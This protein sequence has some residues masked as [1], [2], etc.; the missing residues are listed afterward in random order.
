MDQHSSRTGFVRPA[1]PT[2]LTIIPPARQPSPAIS[3]I[4][5]PHHFHSGPGSSGART[6]T[7]T[8]PQNAAQKRRT[9]LLSLIDELAQL[10]DEDMERERFLQALNDEKNTGYNDDRVQ[11]EGV[12]AF[13]KFNNR[14]H[15]LDKELQSFI[16]AVRQLGSSVGLL[17]SAYH[18]RARLTQLL[19]L[20][21]ENAAELFRDIHR[22][23]VQTVQI[24]RFTSRKRW[25]RPTQKMKPA[26]K[27]TSDPEALPEQLGLLAK[28]LHTFLQCLNQIPEFTDEAVNS[29]AMS[30]YQDLMYW[31][32]CLK[33]YEGQF[34]W[35]SVERYVND[36]TGEMGEH[37]DH[38]S[39]ALTTF[40][41]V[42]VPTIR[43]TQQHTANGLQNLSTVA[44]FFS[45]VTASTL[46][47]SYQT[48]STKTEEAVNL[49]WVT[50]LVFS[51]A[52]AINSQLAY[53]WRS[54]IYRSPRACVPWWVSIWITR[55]PLMFLVSSVIAFSAGLV[56][57]TYSNFGG[58]SFIPI[59]TTVCTSISSFALFAVGF[60]FA[61]ERYAFGK[62][63]GRKWLAEILRD[64]IAA[65]K[66]YSGYHYF[67]THFPGR[68]IKRGIAAVTFHF[69]K[70]R[71]QASRLGIM[72][73]ARQ[74]SSTASLENG[75]TNSDLGYGASRDDLPQYYSNNSEPG[76]GLTR[77]AT[78]QSLSSAS[79]RTPVAVSPRTES[80]S[81]IKPLEIK[82][83]PPASPPP[84]S[85]VFSSETSA[86]TPSPASP[87]Q[88][89]NN[90]EASR[91]PS[92]PSAGRGRF[93]A[94]VNK[95]VLMNRGVGFGPFTL[96]P[97][98]PI[99]SE[100]PAATL[101][102]GR[103]HSS[104]NHHP[105]MS[106]R[107]QDSVE[108]QRHS[109][110][111][112]PPSR[113]AAIVPAL[114]A[115]TTTQYLS[116]H[117]AL[118]RHLQFSPSGEYFATCSWDQTAIIWKV[119]Q[120]FTIH[121]KLAHAKG[122][123]GQVAWSP[124][125]KILLTKMTRGVK[126]WSSET[127]VCQ[128]TIERVHNIQ[129]VTWMPN[130]QNF[131]SVE[132]TSITMLS[133]TGKVEWTAQL[134]HLWMHDVV[135]TPDETRLLAVATL[136]QSPDGLK[137]STSPHEKRIL[138]YNLQSKEIENQTPVLNEV[139][140]IT[141]SVSGTS[142]LVSYEHRAAPQLFR[143]DHVRDRGARLVLLHT[144]VPPK[145]VDFAGASYLGHV[146]GTG[147]TEDQIVLCAGK[148][149]EVHIWDRE[150]AKLL[151]LLR[152]QDQGSDL[153]GIAWNN[154]SPNQL[155]FASAT[156]DGTVRIWTAPW[157]GVE[158]K[159][160]RHQEPPTFSSQPQQAPPLQQFTHTRPVLSPTDTERPLPNAL[161][162][163]TT[164]RLESPTPTTD[165]PSQFI[166]LPE[167][168]V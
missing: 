112:R 16:N 103:K 74:G 5:A 90:L 60:W 80:I 62:T 96:Q 144:Y 101:T 104:S 78:P 121:R 108:A 4:D 128:R 17:S 116:E 83:K 109:Q 91:A 65:T 3:L 145:K 32:S 122:F 146:S 156:H 137:P 114:K 126:V 31:S 82:E 73:S 139:R 70:A 24:K 84:T 158:M 119:G 37:L 51:L 68:Y 46:Q 115:L 85:I 129:S 66:M 111:K 8:R 25:K 6:P 107:R 1:Q 142:A 35:P 92:Q 59:V 97:S 38:I 154:S 123:V 161:R 54:A 152:A 167:D 87:S 136:E 118:V 57:F 21:R 94:L 67:T 160:P 163:A 159:P 42:G 39:E 72:I 53:H 99:T 64:F 58:A 133:L 155:M 61:G 138:I 81:E 100:T 33:D 117:S 22:E 153:T 30:F 11:K 69:N 10:R 71:N 79:I 98:R 76:N 2:N 15:R 18:L 134:N 95:V 125:G 36:L 41:E 40:I 127:G 23:P 131:I 93:K 27:V 49:L 106:Y 135:V 50:S 56:C 77:Y 9:T 151:H 55:T 166:R 20:F 105:S 12:A 148:S 140:D 86:G 130:C 34:R 45:A 168:I 120:P 47:Y 157:G 52:S 43:F 113:L 165:G 143:I 26:A 63:K 162:P 44:T 150:T 124:N 29:S 132:G 147:G 48:H 19:H 75:R 110:S 14:F 141:L 7:D 164:I 102:S 149:G 28:D 13:M 88:A 89:Q